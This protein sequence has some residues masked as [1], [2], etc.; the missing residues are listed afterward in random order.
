MKRT[1]WRR[2]AA[3][4]G[5]RLGGVEK[6]GG[7]G[8]DGEKGEQAGSKEW[9]EEMGSVGRRHVRRGRQCRVEA[10]AA[11]VASGPKLGRVGRGQT[12]LGNYGRGSSRP[13]GRC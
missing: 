6:G 7:G 13:A 8:E 11:A 10:R 4:G 1:V 5:G 12:V 2:W 3:W 9:V